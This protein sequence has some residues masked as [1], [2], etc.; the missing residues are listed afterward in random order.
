MGED[1]RSM[2]ERA[3]TRNLFPILENDENPDVPADKTFP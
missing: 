2:M 3:G 1:V